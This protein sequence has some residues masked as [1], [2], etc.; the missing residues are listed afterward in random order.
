MARILVEGTESIANQR[1]I[2]LA[3]FLGSNNGTLLHENR[4]H[5]PHEDMNC[6]VPSNPLGQMQMRFIRVR[7]IVFPLRI[8]KVN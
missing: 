1:L 7:G 5:F 2:N 3:V 4:F 8:D 6:V